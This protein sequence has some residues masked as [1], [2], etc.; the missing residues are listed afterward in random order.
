MP[1]IDVSTLK[2]YE[3][4]ARAERRRAHEVN[5][6]EQAKVWD[7]IVRDLWSARKRLNKALKKGDGEIKD[8]PTE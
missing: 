8:G 2:A 1:L 3:M 6:D 7:R 5:D 4:E